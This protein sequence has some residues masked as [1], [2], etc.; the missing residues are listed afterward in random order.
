LQ[1]VINAQHVKDY[2]KSKRGI[3][4]QECD[5]AAATDIVLSVHCITFDAR[6]KG[7]TNPGLACTCKG[8]AH[9]HL[10]SHV[11]Y[12]GALL[13]ILHI[14]ICCTVLHEPIVEHAKGGRKKK[15]KRGR[16]VS[17]SPERSGGT[18][19]YK[20]KHNLTKKGKRARAYNS[21]HA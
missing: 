13:H 16:A 19:V 21:V 10:C 12:I 7:K 11:L 1:E 4:P 6:H 14:C 18:A 3:F 9:I 8:W 17:P 20:K 5:K 15:T 2:E